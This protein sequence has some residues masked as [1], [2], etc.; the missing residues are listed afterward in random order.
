MSA[1]ALPKG[2]D[3]Y[4]AL[5]VAWA[6]D[7]LEP[8]DQQDFETH[9]DGCGICALAVMSALRVA[10]ELAYGVPDVEPPALL[11]Q[12]VLAAATPR[13][14]A[15]GMSPEG[16]TGQDAARRDADRRFAP[17]D[18]RRDSVSDGEEADS[19]GRH[20]TETGGLGRPEAETGGAGWRGADSGDVRP[21]GGR[22]G[23][24]DPGDVTGGRPGGRGDARRGAGAHRST[25]RR[26]DGASL[27]RGERRAVPAG[28]GPAGRAAERGP[29]VR[30]RRRVVSV[31]VAAALVGLSAVT[32]WQ[33]TRPA[34]ATA[35]VVAAERVAALSTQAGERTLATVIVR[36]DRA[37]VVTD[38]LAPN[39]GRNTQYVVW[40]VPDGKSGTPQVV[41]SFEVTAEGLHSYPVR[42]SQSLDGYPVLAVS[43]EKAGSTPTTPSKV[44]ARGALGR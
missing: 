3:Q 31:L 21:V 22:G 34:P 26:R 36:G 30:G 44:L 29:G 7:A 9:R 15:P 20:G 38:G 35:P 2:H 28:R 6:I 12:R 33:V 10:A 27:S 40:G 23:E 39:A 4:E 42:L 16:S 1:P 8:A 24:V 5:A 43:E 37:N 14:P 13:P 32:T 25:G 17:G 19:L 41:G 18:P 11:R